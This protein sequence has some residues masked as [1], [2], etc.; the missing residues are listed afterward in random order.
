MNREEK[1]QIIDSLTGKLQEYPHFYI[2]D[3]SGLNAEQTSKLRRACYE[4]QIAL[5]VVK[6]TLFA[7]ALE[8]VEKVDEQITGILKGTSAI[9]FTQTGNAPAKLI[10]E[11]R[12]TSEKPV[13]KGA[14]VEEC[15]YLGDVIDELA[16]VKSRDELLGDIIGLLQSPAKN[17]ISALQANAGQKV[18]GLVKALE[19]RGA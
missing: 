4:K 6:N 10:K 16:N 18:A 8:K 17:L 2:T 7:K 13:I 9:M 15:V 5:V 3:T 12:K 14:Y 11:F 19:E 1:A